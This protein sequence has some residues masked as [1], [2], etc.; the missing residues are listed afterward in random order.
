MD[1]VVIPA[2]AGIHGDFAT[3]RAM[4]SFGASV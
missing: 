4:D 3:T 2:Q 1:S